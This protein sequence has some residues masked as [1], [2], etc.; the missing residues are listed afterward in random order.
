MGSCPSGR[1]GCVLVGMCPGREVSEWGVVLV[2]SLPSGE[3][4]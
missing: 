2:G 1:E 3:L 4:S